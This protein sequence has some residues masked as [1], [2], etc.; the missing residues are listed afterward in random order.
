MGMAW[1][2]GTIDGS[3]SGFRSH[4]VF[5]YLRLMSRNTRSKTGT[6][7]SSVTASDYFPINAQIIGPS[8]DGTYLQ[9]NDPYAPS[10]QSIRYWPMLMFSHA[11]SKAPSGSVA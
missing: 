7:T 4:T 1:G 5:A 10:R 6:S 2:D 8:G 11:C 3:S 9:D